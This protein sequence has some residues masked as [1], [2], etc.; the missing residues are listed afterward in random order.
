[1]TEPA[2]PDARE[3]AVIDALRGVIDPEIGLDVVSLG[4]VYGVTF[5]AD[6][7]ATVRMTM[8]TP[9]CPLGEVIA[10]DAV[11]AARAVDGVGE[12]RVELVW[13]PPWTPDRMSPEA[14]R[15]L[16]WGPR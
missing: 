13:D 12:V 4:L 6:G 11:N 7:D 1:M 3:A 16:G 8:T 10:E 2:A 9:A 15:A 5:D 14:Q